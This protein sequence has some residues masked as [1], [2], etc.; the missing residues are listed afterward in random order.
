M[1]RDS[2]IFLILNQKNCFIKNIKKKI[3][4]RI[5]YQLNLLINIRNYVNTKNIITQYKKN[6][7]YI[8]VIA[9]NFLYSILLRFFVWVV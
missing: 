3:K 7:N 5:Q 4:I 1:F 8:R 6:L 9:Y 2:I